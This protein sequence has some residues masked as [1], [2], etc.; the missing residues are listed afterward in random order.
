MLAFELYLKN[1]GFKGEF[2]KNPKPVKKIIMKG[3]SPALDRKKIDEYGGALLEEYE[4]FQSLFSMPANTAS[5]LGLKFRATSPNSPRPYVEIYGQFIRTKSGAKISLTIGKDDKSFNAELDLQTKKEK[6][7]A[8]NSIELNID[9]EHYFISGKG[10]YD[11]YVKSRVLTRDGKFQSTLFKKICKVFFK[12]VLSRWKDGEV[13][14][15]KISFSLIVLPKDAEVEY[16]SANDDGEEDGDAVKEFKDSFGNN[17][18]SYASEPTITA[19]FLSYDDPAFSINCTDSERFYRNLSMGNRSHRLVN[20]NAADS[21]RISGLQWM[22]TDISKPGRRFTDTKKGIYYQLW[23][24]YKDLDKTNRLEGMSQLKVLCYLTSQAKMEVMLDE[25]LTMGEMKDL[26]SGLEEREIPPQAFEVLIETKGKTTIWAHY[27]VAVRSLLARKSVDKSYLLSR[28][29]LQLRSNLFSWLATNAVGDAASFF[30][31]CDFCIKVLYKNVLSPL[32]AGAGMNS[33][34]QYAYQVGVIAAEYVRFKERS[35]ES[36]NSL[37]D[38]LAYSRYD[39]EKLRFVMQRV[40]LG[41]SLSKAPQDKIKNMETFITNNQPSAEIRDEAAYN[42]YSYFF[43]K[44][45]FAKDAG[46]Q[47]AGGGGQPA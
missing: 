35:G 11:E 5:N 28:F 40:G 9:K 20:I 14:N 25:N 34:E 22:F 6:V 39:R 2:V 21:F 1:K 3:S 24:N 31:K 43:Y 47:V 36:S 10:L 32:G 12:Y 33:D 19:K 44:G 4:S 8:K 41:L 18:R 45:Y 15:G 42:D 7:T 16:H 13:R 23:K 29:V 46:K 38:I 17:A 30:Q 37:R 26:F 27:L